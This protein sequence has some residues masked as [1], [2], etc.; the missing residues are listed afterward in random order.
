MM[1]TTTFDAND[2]MSAVID[3][4][5]VAAMECE[6]LREAIALA[7]VKRTAKHYPFIDIEIL[8]EEAEKFAATKHV[9]IMSVDSI[10]GRRRFDRRYDFTFTDDYEGNA[11]TLERLFKD[12]ND[13][14]AYYCDRISFEHDGSQF[15]GFCWNTPSGQGKMIG[16]FIE[17]QAKPEDWDYE[18]TANTQGNKTTTTAST[19]KEDLQIIT[20]AGAKWNAARNAYEHGTAFNIDDVNQL[21]ADV[22]YLKRT[23]K[24]YKVKD[25]CQQLLASLS[26]YGFQ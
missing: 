5:K 7:V 1:S 6:H 17:P 14:Q 21:T 10:D 19:Y 12:L 25:M 8:H 24:S 23:T 18:A 9:I 4:K 3:P 16:Y 11:E 15:S 26:E 20:N 22:A 13:M 2:Y